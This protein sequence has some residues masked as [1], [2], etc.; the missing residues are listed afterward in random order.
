MLKIILSILQLIFIVGCGENSSSS[1]PPP[2]ATEEPTQEP[3]TPI[4]LSN[5]QKL[6]EASRSLNFHLTSFKDKLN[7]T[8]KEKTISFQDYAYILKNIEQKQALITLGSS[9][10][11]FFEK[12][13]SLVINTE[14]NQLP[15]LENGYRNI[16][17][18]KETT[19]DD[20]K[21]E[22]QNI[23]QENGASVLSYNLNDIEKNATIMIRGI[24]NTYRCINKTTDDIFEVVVDNSYVSLPS[25][26]A[27]HYICFDEDENKVF[28]YNL[29]FKS[30]DIFGMRYTFNPNIS[31]GA[32]IDIYHII[33][34]QID[35]ESLEKSLKSSN[36]IKENDFLVLKVFY[37]KVLD[38]KEERKE[39]FKNRP[40]TLPIGEYDLYY[41][42]T[43]P[44]NPSIDIDNKIQSP[45]SVI[46]EIPQP[47]LIPNR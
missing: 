24:N 46:E 31:D 35:I 10:F 34:T 15:I 39:V 9:K 33:D 43:S 11:E 16:I 41:T 22:L 13:K 28:D 27:G 36:S 12:Q 20:I 1:T 29:T 18:N 38:K 40:I 17:I 47:K 32:S 23:F 6:N 19:I 5:I 30:S 37:K 25:N 42:L 4:S 8:S 14:M 26:I 7:I 21:S 45:F 2:V 44:Q 3:S